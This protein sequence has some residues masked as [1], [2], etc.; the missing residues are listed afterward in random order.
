MLR[1]CFAMLLL[2][3]GCVASS[4]QYVHGDDPFAQLQAAPKYSNLTVALVISD[5]TRIALAHIAATSKIDRKLLQPEYPELDPQHLVADINGLLQSQFKEIHKIENVEQAKGTNA[6]VVMLLDL[7]LQIGVSL[8]RE[9]V[10]TIEATIVSV[11]GTPIE[12]IKANGAIRSAAYD[13]AYNFSFAWKDALNKFKAEL[14]SSAKLGEYNSGDRHQ[15]VESA[16][17]SKGTPT[18]SEQPIAASHYSKVTFGNY[19]ALVVGNNKYTKVTP[20]I[21]A[22]NDARSVADVLQHDYGFTVNLMLNATRSQMLDALDSYRRTLEESDNL[23]IYYAGHGYL[24]TDSD[25]GYWIPVDAD[26]NRRANWLSNS[27]IA[28]SVRAVRAI[29]V[30]VIADSCYSGTLIRGLSVEMTALDDFG[31]LAK[32]RART[33]LTSGGLEPVQDAGGGGHSIFA[34]AFLDSLQKNKGVVD[35]SQMFS[36]MRREVMLSSDQ[37]PRYGDIRQAGHEGGDFIFVRTN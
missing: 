23:L 18:P 8:V 13:G 12:D 15:R 5:N 1:L 11:D 17:L 27:D 7:Q 32:K 30:L 34:Q 16:S 20:L 10:T 31:R 36:D 29:H 19:Y 14:G 9:N 6:D 4:P 22:E 35:M 33:A 21:T 24:D 28:D 26:S 25:R 2:L 37:T 3:A